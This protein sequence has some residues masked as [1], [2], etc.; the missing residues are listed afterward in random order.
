MTEHVGYNE[1]LFHKNRLRSIYHTARYRWLASLH[2]GR[3]KWRDREWVD[4]LQCTSPREMPD[5][6]FF[7]IGICM[8]ALNMMDY[9]TEEAYVGKLSRVCGKLFVTV[10]REHGLTFFAKHVTKSM[11]YGP[12]RIRYSWSDVA[13]MTLGR[14]NKVERQEYKGFDERILFRIISN[15]FIVEKICGLFPPSFPVPLSSTIG[16]VGRSRFVSA[17]K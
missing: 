3:E 8:E 16:L 1:R 6:G 11:L 13:L 5:C 12:A 9:D 2:Q 17:L 7:D 15:Y 10:P 4:L 14:F